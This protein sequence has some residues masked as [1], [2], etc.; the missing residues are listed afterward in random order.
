MSINQMC[1][2]IFPLTTLKKRKPGDINF[3]D[4][5]YLTQWIQ[6]V[7]ISH[8]INMKIINFLFLLCG[9]TL[10]SIVQFA[11]ATHLNLN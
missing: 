4:V 5:C 6:N 9:K 8:V 11:H 3:S 2:F 10:E 7:S 1:N